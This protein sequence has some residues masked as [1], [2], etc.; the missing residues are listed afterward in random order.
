[1]I[2][3]PP[4]ASGYIRVLLIASYAPRIKGS[5]LKIDFNKK[6]IEIQSFLKATQNLNP[7]FELN[8]EKYI[9]K[10]IGEQIVCVQDSIAKILDIR[11]KSLI[12]STKNGYIELLV[13]NTNSFNK[14][15]TIS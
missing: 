9:V 6:N 14:G 7:F 4:S 1:M 8:N 12:I 10:G 11:N 5:F 3:T 13:E 2:E 15:D